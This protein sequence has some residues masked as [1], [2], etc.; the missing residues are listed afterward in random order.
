[1]RRSGSL[2]SRHAEKALVKLWTRFIARVVL[3]R[4]GS[5][6]AAFAACTVVAAALAQPAAID[7]DRARLVS[8][9][10]PRAVESHAP[11]ANFERAS[12]IAL[13]LELGHPFTNSD[14]RE[15]A[16]V[17]TAIDALP[18]VARVLSLTN[19]LDLRGRDGILAAAPLIELEPETGAAAPSLEASWERV[20]G[21]RWYEGWLFTPAL[22]AFAL[23]IWIAGE[24]TPD[25]IAA[26]LHAIQQ[27]LD[28]LAPPWPHR[29]SS[30]R[31][32][33]ELARE[34]ARGDLERVGP[35]LALLFAAGLA[36]YTRSLWTALAIV[37]SIAFCE[38]VL[39]VEIR[40]AGAP[41]T[42]ATALAP[43]A[44][45][46]I[47]VLVLCPAFF[48]ARNPERSGALS[49][50]E[51]AA[52]CA[53]PLR[54]A[55]TSVLVSLALWAN[56]I[57][58]VSALGAGL[59]AGSL[60]L[61]LVTAIALPACLARFG[62]PA[63]SRARRGAALSVS[64][65][66]IARA[67]Q[68]AVLGAAALAVAL[69]PGIAAL[70][71]DSDLASDLRTGHALAEIARSGSRELAGTRSLDLVIDAH[72]P[73]AALDPE[74]LRL[75][76]ALRDIAL[77][78][79]CCAR[80]SSALD[81]L[82][83]IDSQLREGATPSE[84]PT[85]RERAELDWRL[86]S[87]A[88]AGPAPHG[89]LNADHSQLLLRLWLTSDSS[90]ALLELRD[91]LLRSAANRSRAAQLKVA[92]SS[93]LEAL[94][95]RATS[96]GSLAGMT[97]M[98]AT[99]ALTLALALRSLWLALAAI[100]PAVLALAVCASAL[101]QLGIPLDADFALLGCAVIAVAMADSAA[102]F[103]G[104]RAVPATAAE[105]SARA[106]AMR[107]SGSL[108]AVSL[109]PLTAAHF[110][111]LARGAFV[112]LGAIAVSRLVGMLLAPSLLALAGRG[113][114]SSAPVAAESS[115]GR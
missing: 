90:E 24:S 1:V 88:L 76:A 47:S 43:L 85:S 40:A 75:A 102:V 17:S 81:E 12:E 68:L 51:I 84:I 109:A 10:E 103:S 94:A 70:R 4:A 101:G 57:P 33:S 104:A 78:E 50:D 80:T 93:Y 74:T 112:L 67:P 49:T 79:T 16:D 32:L 106:E 77:G 97:A 52:R 22:D 69:F 83:L 95:A 64:G 110:A 71:F 11:D 30:P 6:L 105:W 34:T 42:R 89:A 58:A 36:L 86:F 115:A 38:S 14:L 20:F 114:V 13:V 45:F 113:L 37:T 39:F 41:L 3:P 59:G 15:L 65:L 98:I 54:A 62:L 28:T 111:P 60:A 73:G 7:L 56:E 48:C 92:G 66:R 63:A 35:L 82:W 27:T 19:A 107:R 100:L 8:E 2:R 91:Q 96:V 46:S 99:A 23:R 108:L 55:G 72:E 44:L 18:E 9:R 5:I 25:R 31:A 29:V 21:H 53:P 87:A 61:G 26:A